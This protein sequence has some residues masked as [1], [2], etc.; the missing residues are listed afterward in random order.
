MTP[1]RDELL[2]ASVRDLG[3][4]LD[5][6][7]AFAPATLAGWTYHG[8]SLGLPAWIER[9]TWKTFAKAFVRE[10]DG[11]VRGWNVRC[12]QGDPADL[13]TAAQGRRAGDLR[14]LPG[15]VARRRLAR[16][17]P[18][19]QRG[20]AIRS[21]ERREAE[22]GGSGSRAH[23]I[24]G[25]YVLGAVRDPLVALDDRGDRLLGRTLVAVAGRQ[26]PT[27]SFFL[28]ERGTP[29]EHVAAAPRS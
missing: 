8:T 16:L 26:L 10:P 22:G 2:R 9:L 17:R 14:P 12:E 27:P 4:A 13:A 18:R 15:R 29:V 25:S 6:G 11:R 19:R 20:A 5:A 1:T 28:L 7:R 24:I 3:R 23:S 21:A